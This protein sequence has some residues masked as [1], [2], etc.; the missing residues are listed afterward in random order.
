MPALG[1]A[2][3]LLNVGRLERCIEEVLKHVCWIHPIG[4]NGSGSRVSNA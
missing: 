2:F 4:K 1:S 3:E